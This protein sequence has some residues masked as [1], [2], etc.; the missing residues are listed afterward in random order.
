[1]P[2]HP[3]GLF[4]NENLKDK[5]IK[6]L[7]TWQKKSVG[8]YASSMMLFYDIISPL[9][10][11][12]QAYLSGSQKEYMQKAYE[13]IAE[14]YKNPDFSYTVGRLR[15]LRKCAGSPTHIIFQMCLKNKRGFLPHSTLSITY[16]CRYESKNKF[17]YKFL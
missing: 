5:F 17:F 6:L 8:Y 12:Q 13:Y 2:K 9:Q 1:M 10:K 14:N 3:I 16:D 4:N 15:K 11:Q 7:N